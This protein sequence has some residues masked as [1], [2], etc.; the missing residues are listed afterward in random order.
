MYLRPQYKMRKPGFFQT[1]K[2]LIYA[3]LCAVIAGFL[4]W[5]W[6]SS[7]PGEQTSRVIVP[8]P[9]PPLAVK[10]TNS[11]VP[12]VAPVARMETHESEAS[13]TRPVK[14]TLEMQIA[15]VR[16]GISPGSLDGAAGAQ[17]RSA[18]MAFQQRRGI[19]PTG[20][21]DADTK[22]ALLITPPITT[23]Y[24]ITSE[25]LGRLL[26]VPKTW[27]GK[28]EQPRL[29]FENI[30]ELLGEKSFSHPQLIRSLNPNIDWNSVTVGTTVTIPQVQYPPIN[31]KAALVRI[32]LQDR[33]LEAFD[34]QSNLL[35]HFPC[36]IGRLA[37][38]RPVGELHVVIIVFNPDYTFD[39]DVFPESSEAQELG[40]KLIIPP[41]PNNPVGVAWIGL[42]RPG[43]GIHG[44]PAPEQVGRTESHG[45]FRL[46]NW[47][48][49]YLA[50]MSWV[51]MPVLVE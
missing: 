45:C 12:V 25:D 21:L 47:N 34:E 7:R 23:E 37:E 14:T 11:P 10:P 27:L 24:T 3:L 15:L 46:A 22:S 29:D 4:I 5:I 16:Q 42:D 13:A 49:D 30:L 36:S 9:A 8:V 35:V 44:T 31:A 40:R 48:A 28:S 51:G 6:S 26:P 1:F 32:S 43:Y 50:R 39:P 41:G 19:T 18:L 2:K 33:V 20:V 38:K 17:T